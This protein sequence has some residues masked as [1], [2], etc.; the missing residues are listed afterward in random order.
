MNPT[1]ILP[2]N[3][4]I[5]VCHANGKGL[6]VFALRHIAMGELIEIA[7]VLIIPACLEYQILEAEIS[8]YVFEW[9][10]DDMAI[11]LGYGSFYNHSYSPNAKYELQYQKGLIEFV[12]AR[13]I[14]EGD[15]IK[16]NYNGSPGDTSP[17]WFDVL[18]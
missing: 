5:A 4:K 1:P 8:N 2:P 18:E 16:V 3:S 11:A 12:A 10:K 13:E 17:V 7:P 14:D 15:E 9:E 6:G